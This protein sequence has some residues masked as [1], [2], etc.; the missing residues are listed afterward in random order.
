MHSFYTAFGVVVTKHRINMIKE[1][2]GLALKLFVEVLLVIRV[3]G[4]V[5]RSFVGYT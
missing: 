1:T 3:F 2:L 5:L 4:F